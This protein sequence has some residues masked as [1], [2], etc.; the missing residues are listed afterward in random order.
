M[1]LFLFDA[2]L[3]YDAKKSIF[4]RGKYCKILSPLSSDILLCAC[5]DIRAVLFP[6]LFFRFRQISSRCNDAKTDPP[7]WFT[8]SSQTRQ[9]PIIVIKD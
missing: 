2:A 1:V 3:Q 5:R 9:E 8:L 6:G 4:P 7:H